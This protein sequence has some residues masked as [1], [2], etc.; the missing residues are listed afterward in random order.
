VTPDI[1]IGIDA[2]TSVIKS[3][4]F[5]LSGDLIAAAS[6]PNTY[7]VLRNGGAEQDMALT[8]RKVAQ[9]LRGLSDKVPDLD[10]RAAAV[11]VTAQGDGT[12]LIDADGEPVAPSWLWLDV[13]A[14]DIADE[15]V[16]GPDYDR[17]FRTTGTAL[18]ACQQSIHLAWLKRGRPEVLARAATALHCKDWLYFKLTGVRA[19]DPAEASFTYG[20][21]R[22]RDYAMELLEPIGIADQKRLLPPIVDGSRVSHPLHAA[23]ARET[24]LREGTPVILA[25]LDVICV[26]LGAGVLSPEGDRGCTILGS[27]GMHMRPAR[28]AKDVVLNPGQSGYVMP[29][30]G[31]PMLAQMQSNMAASLNVDWISD[32]AREVLALVGVERSREEVLS[33]IEK[34]VLEQP[35]AG[36]IYHPYISEAGERGPFLDQNARA[37][38][39]GLSQQTTFAG[40]LRGVY[41]GL[42]MAAL[43]CYGAMGPVPRVVHIAGGVAKS[44]AIRTILASV[45]GT[46]IRTLNREEAGAAGAAM[47]AA[48]QLKLYPNMTACAAVWVDPHLGDLVHPDPRLQEIY[49]DAFA[50]YRSLRQAV[51]PSWKPLSNLREKA[52]Q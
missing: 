15:V 52:A 41:E 35:P 1:L 40:L 45:L 44:R 27:T 39:T 8:W 22:T 42:S 6:V 19:T 28:S 38:F 16:A 3:I 9:T 48:I 11:A 7:E 5:T 24:G 26:G 46:P 18:N 34:T 50:I 14:T 43:D 21:F 33:G 29:F 17:H 25:A 2:G 37:Q 20:D 30:P 31:S 12:W 51:R 32:R 23:G 36:V 10:R 49:R 4:A 13:R 47:T